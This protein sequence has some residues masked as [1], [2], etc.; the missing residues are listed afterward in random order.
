MI[1]EILFHFGMC[2]ITC[3]IVHYFFHVRGMH[4]VKHKSVHMSKTKFTNEEMLKLRKFVD[5]Y[6]AENNSLNE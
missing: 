5:D 1:E 6:F 3:L 2:L 4:K